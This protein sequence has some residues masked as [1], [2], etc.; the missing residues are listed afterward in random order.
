MLK[1]FTRILTCFS[2]LTYAYDII[3]ITN[4][5]PPN[6]ALNGTEFGVIN[7]FDDSAATEEVK[8]IFE[9]AMIIFKEEEKLG[10]RSVGWAQ[11]DIVKNPD[12]AIASEDI[13]YPS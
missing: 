8:K 6:Q 1:L 10:T 11:V 2:S 7:F 12:L 13:E 4:E 5:N 3:E 9:K